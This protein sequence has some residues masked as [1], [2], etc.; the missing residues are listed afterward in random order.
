MHT[1]KIAIIVLLGNLLVSNSLWGQRHSRQ[2]Y[3]QQYKEMAIQEMKRAKIP[4]SITL[5]QGI[6]ESDCGNSVLAKKS[7][8]HFGIKC[9]NDW[10]GGRSYH[11]DDKRNECFRKYKSAYES[12]VDHSNFLTGRSRYADLFNLKI[13]DYKGWAHGLKKAGYATDPSYARRLIKIIEEEQL[14]RFDQMR[15]KAGRKAK[16][17]Q[18]ADDFVISPFKAHEVEFNN[19]VR[20][21]A[22]QPGDSFEAIAKEF[23]LQA[24]ELYQYND[25]PKN[26]SISDYKH[27]Y[28]QPKKSKAHRDHFVHQVKEG[29]TLQQISN[30]YGVKLSKLE[31]YNGL[32]RGQK[33]PA[34]STIQLRGK[35]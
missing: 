10:K 1:L 27:I 14:Y 6:L 31:K 24:W 4:A 9:H 33:P 34:G 29:E 26:G 35:K 15:G 5:A 8:N 30:K 25:I 21:I 13:T 22:I 3:I 32:G 23:N 19:G 2:D 12:F 18:A 7:N 28:I 20:Y 17:S 11:D 16:A